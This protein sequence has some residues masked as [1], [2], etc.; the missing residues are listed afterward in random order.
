MATK[1]NT[2]RE[3]KAQELINTGAVTL[4]L[5]RGYAE[6]K[7][8][9]SNVYRVTK[10][11]CCCPDRTKRGQACKHEL[12]VKALC[13]MFREHR[14]EA[15]AS[16]KTRMPAALARALANA[17][18]ATAPAAKAGCTVCSA[19]TDFDICSGCFFGQVAA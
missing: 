3:A 8:S 6:V 1:S 12:A 19:P 14:A 4:Y 7:G 16:G 17:T 15:K 10:D 2:S 18:P 9:G 11:G 13:E 5:G